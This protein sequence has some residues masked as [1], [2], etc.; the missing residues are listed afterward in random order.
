MKLERSI[1][2]MGVLAV[3]GLTLA[4]CGSDANV[5]A[6]GS[7]D[8]AAT[9]EGKS[10]ITGEG[11]S[12]QQNAMSNFTSVYSA[13]CADKQVEYTVSG[14]GNGRTQFVAGLVDF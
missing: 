12:A 10:P 9:C 2:L 14:S 13:V 7:G 6:T 5:E 3:G 1:A 11:S 4:A 8:S